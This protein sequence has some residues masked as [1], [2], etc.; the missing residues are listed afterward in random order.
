MKKIHNTYQDIKLSRFTNRAQLHIMLELKEAEAKAIA[1]PGKKVKADAG[2]YF[3]LPVNADK[4]FT[5]SIIEEH[6]NGRQGLWRVESAKLSDEGDFDDQYTLK[7]AI[8][9]IANIMC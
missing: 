3:Y 4:V 5:I 1:N 7:E 6:Y 2:M 8:A 9:S